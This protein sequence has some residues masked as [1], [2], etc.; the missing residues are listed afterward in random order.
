M[1]HDLFVNPNARHRA[2][3]PFL[4]DLQGN[5]VSGTNRVI[6]PLAR[7]QVVDGRDSRYLPL[8]AHE[9]TEYRVM[10]TLLASLP[11]HVLRNA[12]G[13]IREARF[14]IT[15]GLDWLFSGL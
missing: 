11:A 4:A 9:G 2:I 13:T 6:A 14:E 7:R 5:L 15:R 1:Q 10:L 12:V 3:Y 8:I